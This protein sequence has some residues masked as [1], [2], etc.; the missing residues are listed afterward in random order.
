[1]Q[2]RIRLANHDDLPT[3]AQPAPFFEGAQEIRMVRG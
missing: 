3:V 1:M 2:A